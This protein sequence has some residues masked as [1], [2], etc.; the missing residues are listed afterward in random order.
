[1]SRSLI[2]IVPRD[3][4]FAKDGRGFYTSDVGRGHGHRWPL[5][6]TVRGALRAALGRNIMDTSGRRLEPRDYEEVTRGLTIE[7]LLTLH[8]RPGEPFSA[9]HDLWPTP[10]DALYTSS[11]AGITITRLSPEPPRAGTLGDRDDPALEALWRPYPGKQGKGAE[12]PMFWSDA[13]MMRWLWSDAPP[14]DQAAAG[15][16]PERRTQIHV[17][18]DEATLAAK[19]SM[20]FSEDIVETIGPKGSE[21]AIGVACDLP[22]ETRLPAGP[23]PLGGKRR[24]SL[25]EPIDEQV[26]A[27]PKELPAE[28]S[29]LR[30]VLATPA[31]FARGVVPE[32]FEVN[33]EN[34]YVG[35]LPNIEGAVVMRAA[36]VP[37]PLDVSSW[38]TVKRAPRKTRRLVPAGAVYFFTKENGAPFRQDEL[39]ALWLC[40]WGLDTDEGLGLALPGVWSPK[41]KD[42]S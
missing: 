19:P 16:T 38:D 3:G 29:S 22:A 1:M 31:L 10:A 36:M 39:R 35:R 37:G 7:K 24:L 11:P 30:L 28:C 41:S 14:I 9:S 20:L 4:I 23:L 32:G 6:M 5:P 27:A 40:R 26:C 18:I 42:K 33:K 15:L 12:R 2:A 8:R 34:L 21:W 13:D 25:Q 17:T